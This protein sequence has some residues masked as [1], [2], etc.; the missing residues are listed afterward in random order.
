MKLP[1]IL[2]H[3]VPDGSSV[4]WADFLSTLTPTEGAG[5]VLQSL[6]PEPDAEP[7]DMAQDD[8][9]AIGVF[10]LDEHNAK[11]L[12][13]VHP[14]KWV[15]PEPKSSYNLVV[16]GG[17]A[18]GLVSSAGAAGV[19]ARMALI[20]LHL[21]GGDCLN[22]GC[23]QSKALLRCAKAAA[24]VRDAGQFGIRIRGSSNSTPC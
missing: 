16:I 21:L 17:G 4:K 23:V 18:G 20:E 22:V 13:N 11:L 3:Q 6:L 9:D 14:K 12:D 5:G 2:Y 7:A 10:P 19:G 8:L 24:A 1:S 15:D